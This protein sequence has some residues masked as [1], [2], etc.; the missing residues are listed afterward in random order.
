MI[1]S[2]IPKQASVFTTATD[3]RRAVDAEMFGLGSD[4]YEALVQLVL[5]L[6]R[7]QLAKDLDLNRLSKTLSAGLRPLDEELMAEGARSFDDLEAVQRELDSLDRACRAAESF[8]RAYRPYVRAVA[9]G[10]TDDVLDARARTRAAVKAARAAAGAR[11]QADADHKSA[12][13]ERTSV[14]AKIERLGIEKDALQ[15]SEAYQAIGQT[16]DLRA[17]AND[18]VAELDLAVQRRNVASTRTDRAAERVERSKLALVGADARIDQI[19]ADLRAAAEQVIP[20]RI[21]DIDGLALSD[22]DAADTRL[23]LIANERATDLALVEEACSAW[24]QARADLDR[25]D[26]H[27]AKAQG[28]LEN[29]E[30]ELKQAEST[31]TDRKSTRLN[32][33]HTDIPRMPSSA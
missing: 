24:E 13:T 29:A 1:S 21:G 22:A 32:S 12:S 3:Y 7:P 27:L 25:A 14:R 20:N 26:I 28:R 15:R 19:G 16:E 10:R 33:S 5:F 9:R 8:M 17:R 4:R 30:S 23:A 2:K 6:R 31:E 11:D 18:A